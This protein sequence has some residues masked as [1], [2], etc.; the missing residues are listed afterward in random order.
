MP[1]ALINRLI[2][3]MKKDFEVNLPSP[4]AILGSYGSDLPGHIL[5]EIDQVILVAKNT[6][7]SNVE[8]SIHQKSIMIANG[9]PVTAGNTDIAGWKTGMIQTPKGI[10]AY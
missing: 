2:F 5:D 10:I 3:L 7:G 1:Y 9:F 8:P 4:K 6:F